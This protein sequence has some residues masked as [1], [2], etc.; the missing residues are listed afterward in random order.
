MLNNKLKIIAIC[1]MKRSGK[2]TIAD[3]II[4]KY[5]YEKIKLADPLKKAVQI[6]FN[7]TDDQVGDSD[8][9]DKIDPNW[10]ITPRKVMQ[11]FGTEIMQ[12]KI[13]EILPTI[14]RKFWINSLISNMNMNPTKKYIISDLRFLHE[15]EELIKQNV[16]IIKVTRKTELLNED[17]HISEE[18]WQNIPENLLIN[19]DSDIDSLL[20]KVDNALTAM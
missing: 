16:F 2:D 7:F 19:N 1:G 6:L 11:F 14:G 9:K 13:Q 15:Y 17:N 3:H 12:Y 4:S 18:E 5:D 10:G 20:I 8:D